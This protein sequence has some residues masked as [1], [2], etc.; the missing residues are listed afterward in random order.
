MN[1]R[2]AV[3]SLFPFLSFALVS[4]CAA[5][6]FAHDIK[7]AV[8]IRVESVMAANTA[9][10]MDRRIAH[11]PMADRLQ[12]LFEF[13][14][15]RLISQQEQ[16]TVCGRMVAFTLPGGRILH[17]AP[18]AIDD[19]MIAMELILFEGARPIMSTDLK[20]MNHGMLIV[21][22][23][24]YQ[25]GML[26]TTV[27]TDAPDQGGKLTAPPIA[28]PAPEEAAQP[29]AALPAGAVSPAR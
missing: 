6:A 25:Q 19:G 23:P 28:P 3:G 21:G 26:I 20:L 27:T 1:F 13:S 11:T 16:N 10:G 24:R 14:T 9:E 29:S 4:V 17:I 12:A 2:R 22:G 5:T 15:Y 18:R 8:R 7:H